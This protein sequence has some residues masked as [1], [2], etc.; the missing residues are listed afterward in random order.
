MHRARVTNA[1]GRTLRCV[2]RALTIAMRM[3][4][5]RCGSARCYEHRARTW[6]TEQTEGCCDDFL[7]AEHAMQIT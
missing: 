4:G 6:A 1:A 7:Q 2:P 5:R 3:C